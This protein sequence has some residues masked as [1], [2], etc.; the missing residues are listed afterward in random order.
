MLFPAEPVPAPGVRDQPS[1]T[2]GLKLLAA[3]VIGEASTFPTRQHSSFNGNPCAI[4]KQWPSTSPSVGT[5]LPIRADHSENY[6]LFWVTCGAR[7][8]E[9][10]RI[11]ELRLLEGGLFIPTDEVPI[12]MWPRKGVVKAFIPTLPDFQLRSDLM[13]AA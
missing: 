3:Y 7:K 1:C 13:P 11:T 10:V 6:A 4:E 8:F 12:G 9:P 5:Y 2:L